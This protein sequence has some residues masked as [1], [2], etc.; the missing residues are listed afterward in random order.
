MTKHT[1]YIT[2]DG[3]S[4]PL[5][6]SQILP[7]LLGLAD[8]GMQITILSCEKKERLKKE[9]ESIQLVLKRKN[10]QWKYIIYDEG[11]GSLTRLSY[12]NKLFNLSKKE[13]SL[14]KFTLV[15]CRSYLA[16]LIGLKLKKT[17]GIPFLFDMRGFWADERMDGN[18]WKRGNLI[19]YVFFKYF[20]HKEKQFLKYS[21]AIVSLTHAGKDFLIKK[22]P[23][24]N[25]QEKISVIPC[26]VNTSLFDPNGPTT[27]NKLS[28]GHLLIYTGS[29][30]TWY[31][32]K[33]MIDCVLEWR[34][35]IPTIKLL[36]VTRDI[37]ELE[38]IL[39]NYSSAEKKIISFQSASYNQMPSLLSKARASIFF[40]KPAFSKIASSPTKMA[41]CWAMDLPI[42][43]NKGIGDNDIYFNDL[44]G[45]VL[46]QSFNKEEYKKA[47]ENYLHIIS[48]KKDYRQI[49]LSHFNTLD[50]IKSYFNIYN[51]L[52]EN[53]N[54]NN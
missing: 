23:L 52:I 15:H 22:F 54:S 11:G 48:T 27:S 12:V 30:G 31:Y 50:A 41:E 7:Y 25:I 19:Q 4:D 49:A 51:S 37:K 21:D 39:L 45:G 16:S 32:T 47:G 43:T 46:V 28:D 9:V 3:L 2:F 26:C 35:L 29:I 36:I 33:E 18:I 10:I 8:H 20:K 14:K 42:I 38:E 40:I 1:L 17:Y 34:T 6:H 44:N 5:G 24:F 13:H 53:L